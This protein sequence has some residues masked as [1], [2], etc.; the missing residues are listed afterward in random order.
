MCDVR[1]CGYYCRPLSPN[2][3]E[4]WEDLSITSG[5]IS[6]ATQRKA[7]ELGP[8]FV[9]SSVRSIRVPQLLIRA[10]LAVIQHV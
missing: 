10:R 3:V 9:D 2:C 4:P 5:M 6:A 1:S 8:P 7:S